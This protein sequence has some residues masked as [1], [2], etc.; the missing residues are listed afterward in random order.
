MWRNSLVS[1][2]LF[3]SDI[4]VVLRPAH[5]SSAA[6]SLRTFAAASSTFALLFRFS[7]GVSGL[8]FSGS[9]WTWACKS[10]IVELTR[11]TLSSIGTYFSSTSQAFGLFMANSSTAPCSLACSLANSSFRV[12]RCKCSCCSSPRCNTN[13]SKSASVAFA[14]TRSYSVICCC[15]RD[16][17]LDVTSVNTMSTWS[18]VPLPFLAYPC[19]KIL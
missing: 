1:N 12:G 9:S 18:P 6:F 7:G 2:S 19:P 11:W 8:I 16:Q 17:F 13:C 5:S 4:L 15:K 3:H 10:V 14:L